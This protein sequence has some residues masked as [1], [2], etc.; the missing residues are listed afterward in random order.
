[1]ASTKS[2]SSTKA[3]SQVS[4]D[5]PGVVEEASPLSSNT[6]NRIIIAASVCGVIIV[7]T[8]VFFF[9]VPSGEEVA[10]LAEH[11]LIE[12]AGASSHGAISG[13]SGAASGH[14]GAHGASSHG[15]D[16]HGSSSHGAGSHGD[17]TEKKDENR[18]IEQDLGTFNISF[19]P[20]GSDLPYRVE[21]KLYGELIAKDL[22]HLEELLSEKVGRF[23]N[24]LILEIRNASLQELQENQLGLIRRRILATSTEL[25][26]EPILINV[27]FHDYQVIED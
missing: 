6:K 17:G 27:G 14:D 19:I 11:R 1:M 5:A 3:K 9:L 24:R 4:T 13:K 7:E 16:N 15:T 25:L 26:G 12:K 18:T 22:P 20:A 23:R 10:A 8:L 2:V 21:F